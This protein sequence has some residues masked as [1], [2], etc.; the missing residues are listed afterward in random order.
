MLTPRISYR[1][2]TRPKP[3]HRLVSHHEPDQIRIRLVKVR[4]KKEREE[5][6]GSY[7]RRKHRRENDVKSKNGEV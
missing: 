2:Q 5:S 3:Y 7:E 6:S 1:D 4:R